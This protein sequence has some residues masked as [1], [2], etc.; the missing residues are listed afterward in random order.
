MDAEHNAGK[1]WI[2]LRCHDM[3]VDR[4]SG[5]NYSLPSPG[6]ASQEKHDI[7]PICEQALASKHPPPPPRKRFDATGRSFS[8]PSPSPQKQ[9]NM[10]TLLAFGPYLR[11]AST[12]S[13]S[14]RADPMFSSIRLSALIK[15]TTSLSYGGRFFQLHRP[16]FRE[17][18]SKCRTC[19]ISAGKDHP[20]GLT[21]CVSVWFLCY[22]VVHWSTYLS[23]HGY[24][25][26]IMVLR[27]SAVRY[28][29]SSSTLCCGML[30]SP[31]YEL[32][33]VL[34]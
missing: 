14:V 24:A 17:Y 7:S 3:D 11:P 18:L 13:T 26:Y 32:L 6:R 19:P 1:G 8:H 31:M 10:F 12:A 9:M 21:R 23:L 28:L 4:G 27:C 34:N 22:S 33:T 30:C 16:P 5:G 25:C 2:F 20:F 29:V 15:L